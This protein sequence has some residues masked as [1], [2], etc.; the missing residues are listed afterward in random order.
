MNWRVSGDRD[1][2]QAGEEREPWLRKLQDYHMQ[3]IWRSDA[4]GQARSWPPK[5]GEG[6]GPDCS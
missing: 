4:T 1:G 2:G 6:R 3:V 5:A